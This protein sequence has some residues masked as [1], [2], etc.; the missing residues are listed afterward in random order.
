M[1]LFHY[2][3]NQSF[4]EILESRQLW[5]S[6]TSSFNDY[7]EGR[8]VREIYSEAARDI[9]L[10]EILDAGVLSIIDSIF[11]IYRTMAF[12]LSQK[13]DQ[14]SQ[15]RGYADD[16]HGVSIGFDKNEL[17]KIKGEEGWP[18][19]L[20]Q[21]IYDRNEQVEFLKSDLNEV[22]ETFEK[23]DIRYPYKADGLLMPEDRKKEN[24]EKWT[25]VVDTFISV[26][27]KIDCFKN[28]AFEEEKEYRLFVRRPDKVTDY[29]YPINYRTKRN[30]I[31][32]NTFIN[33]G[34]ISNQPIKQIILGPKNESSELNIEEILAKNEM[35]EVEIIR[36][37]AS[38]R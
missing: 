29:P 3:S 18:L 31:I 32:P 33:I 10:G 7:L 34:D 28:P 6:D 13:G 35:L 4:L 9:E 25:E 15:W 21:M 17:E 20:K 30:R 14:L 1:R 2:C 37:K 19:H 24:N 22:K 23:A 26:I 38:Y 16:G 12:C 36:S 5:L 27:T 8:W 11:S